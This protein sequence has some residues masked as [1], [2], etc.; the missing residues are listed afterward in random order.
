MLKKIALPSK[1]RS[2][3]G[4]VPEPDLTPIMS[5]MV[6][7][8]PV[9][10]SVAKLTDL[11]LLE[12]KPPLAAEDSVGGGGEG[13]DDKQDE[14][15]KV[16]LDL[17]VNLHENGI[18]QISMY[19]KLDLGEH[20]YEIQAAP[21]GGYNFNVLNDSLFSIKT[22]EVGDPTGVDS[23][24]N[25]DTNQYE[26]FKTYRIEDGRQ[27]SITAIPET[28]FQ[29]IVNTL[30]VCRYKLKDETKELFPMTMLKQFQ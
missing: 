30:D 1:R 29:S 14:E 8:I 21:E 3:S 25:E 13:D 23:V 24:F 27:V 6:V 4:K 9:L 19:K 10:L 2:A 26:S 15:K 17:L 18:I 7:L 11:A 22:R 5:L 16:N 28:P 20:F 12:Y